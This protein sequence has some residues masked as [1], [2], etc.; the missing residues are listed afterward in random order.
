M[1]N[2]A[3][4]LTAYDQQMRGWIPADPPAGFDYQQVGPLLRIVGQQRGFIDPP[5]DVGLR[6]SDLD[7]LIAR[8]RDFFAARGEAVE[9]KT[10]AHDLPSDL[11]Q[12]LSAAGFVPEDTETVLIGVSEQMATD[13]VLPPGVSLR[14]VSGRADFERIAAMESQV[15]NADWSWLAEDL[16]TRVTAAPS[17]VVVLVA[18]AEEQVVSAAWLVGKPGTQFAGLWG[19]STLAQWRGRGIYRALVARRAQLAR[20]RGVRYLQVD[21]S[22]DSKPILVRLGFM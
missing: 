12:R 16:L 11:P 1:I 10:R 5:V 15:W 3:Q 4:M 2:A 17:D 6:G 21:A 8:Q 13:P 14:Q 20:E 19:G 7:D 22:K 18:E 9:W